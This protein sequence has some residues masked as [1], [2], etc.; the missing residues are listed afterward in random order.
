MAIDQP[1]DLAGKRVWVAGHNG[2]VGH[3]LVRRL[4]R[5][6]CEILTVDRAAL[7]LRRQAEVEAWVAQTRRHAEEAPEHRPPDRARLAP[8]DRVAGGDRADL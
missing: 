6:D 8:V 4:A 5:E 7:D 1:Y 2:M 3:A